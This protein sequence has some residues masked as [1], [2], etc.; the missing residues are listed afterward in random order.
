MV[1]AHRVDTT[2]SADAGRHTRV[3][4]GLRRERAA[5][6]KAP[7]LGGP[8][9][10]KRLGLGRYVVPSGSDDRVACVVRGVGPFLG[11]HTCGCEAGRCGR[12]GW[13]VASVAL[14]RAQEH[15]LA[16]WRRRRARGAAAAGAP[17]CPQDSRG[18][19]D[20]EIALPARRRHHPRPRGPARPA[21][22][23]S[24]PATPAPPRSGRAA[25]RTATAPRPGA[26]LSPVP[27][28]SCAA[29]S[30][31]RRRSAGGVSPATVARWP[32][33]SPRSRRAR[34]LRGRRSGFV[35]RGVPSSPR[36]SVAALTAARAV[37]R[38]GGACETCETCCGSRAWKPGR[39]TRACTLVRMWAVRRV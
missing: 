1:A 34:L 38:R 39:S 24:P 20:G 33:P 12:G 11:D 30:P 27:P 8:A 26:A 23:A 19:R 32:S 28:A 7:A 13:H 35:E 22:A 21:R 17:G 29:R 9:L 5:V 37:R 36:A 16:D 15:A 4:R 2:S 25:T 3:A 10:V 31:A 18:R 6:R 14:R